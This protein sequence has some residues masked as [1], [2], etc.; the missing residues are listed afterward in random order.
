MAYWDSSFRIIL[1]NCEFL[2]CFF[3][4][5]LFN[6]INYFWLLVTDLLSLNHLDNTLIVFNGCFECLSVTCHCFLDFNNS[7][8]LRDICSCWFCDDLLDLFFFNFL[9][10]QFNN[11]SGFRVRCKFFVLN[12][13]FIDNHK[14]LCGRIK[15]GC[16]L[17]K[18]F[19]NSWYH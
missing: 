13:L 7:L 15:S 9:C 18:L 5:F 8:D 19:I 6:N 17:L 14:I 1:N 2:N 3:S 4:S 16:N 12:N 11:W 10:W